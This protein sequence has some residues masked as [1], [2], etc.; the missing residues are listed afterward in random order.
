[1]FV[2][3]R[4]RLHAMHFRMRSGPIADGVMEQ[5]SSLLNLFSGGA[6]TTFNTTLRVMEGVCD[7][8]LVACADDSYGSEKTA[9]TV[10]M[11]PNTDYSIIVGGSGAA[12]FKVNLILAFGW[13]PVR[14]SK[15]SCM[16]RVGSSLRATLAHTRFS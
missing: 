2:S 3:P 1:M 9:L 10:T 6:S 5:D 15:D 11:K 7:G 16:S 4:A 8:S 13:D 12:D 14:D